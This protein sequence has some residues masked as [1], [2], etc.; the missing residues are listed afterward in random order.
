MKKLLNT[1]Y[2]TTE[3][4]ALKKDG[5]TLV[6]EIDGSERA[7]VPLHML[8]SVVAFGPILI[9]PALIGICAERG[10][11]I[12]LMD[13][14]GRFQARIEG[15]VSGNVLL[16]R[17]QYRLADTADDIVRSLVMGKIANQRAVIRRSLRDYGSEM[18]PDAREALE[19]ASDRMALILRRVQLADSGTDALRGSEGEA[20]NLYFAHFDHLIRSPD[21]E[22]RWT[23]RS[24]RPPL[25]A[26]NALLSFLYT[27]LT[28]DCRS[29]CEAVGLDP[30]VGFLHRDRPGRPSLALDLMEEL[31]A[32]LADRLALSLV[33]RR[34]LRAGDFRQMEGGAVLLT[35]DARKLVLTA[36]QERKKEERLH[37]FLAE[38]APFGL[39]PYLQAQMLARHLRG[40]IDAYP[41]WFWS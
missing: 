6:A 33:N 15:P 7:R 12:A 8:A 41:P 1:V 13:R 10:I 40:D 16:R 34:Q 24:R 14:A 17:A 4:A 11:T 21:A 37:P 35:D 27:L 31:R 30:A 2:I 5:E 19:S 39:V 32:P 36:W 22:L 25:D 9:S 3:G 20:A 18:A 23:R 28:H 38:K 26:M 29:A